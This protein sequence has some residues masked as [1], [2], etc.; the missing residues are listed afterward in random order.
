MITQVTK[1]GDPLPSLFSRSTAARRIPAITVLLLS[2]LLLCACRNPLKV[3]K[4]A[5][6]NPFLGAKQFVMLPVTF[7]NLQ[8]GKIQENTYLQRKNPQQQ[9]SWQADKQALAELFLERLKRKISSAKL[10]LVDTAPFTITPRVTRIEPGSYWNPAEVNMSVMISDASGASLDE[11]T[12]SEL[13]SF[14]LL[15]A[16]SSGQRIRSAAE[17][18]GND[19]ATYL[20]KRTKK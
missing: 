12:I 2:L 19:L 7:T 1:A 3:V 11:V 18:S 4:Q 10:M 14:D 17:L 6:P 8:V 16:A 5:N 13:V 9:Q 20:R 15:V